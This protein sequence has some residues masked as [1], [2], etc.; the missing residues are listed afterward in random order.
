MELKEKLLSSFMAFEEQIDVHSELHDVRTT[1]IK[2]FEDKITISKNDILE[3]T[4]LKNCTKEYFVFNGGGKISN[5]N[6]KLELKLINKK[7]IKNTLVT[8]NQTTVA[9]PIK[10]NFFGEISY[11]EFK[12]N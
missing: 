1:A 4:D 12:K 5:G 2:N 11:E 6:N 8:L 9:R 10:I 7:D 3:V